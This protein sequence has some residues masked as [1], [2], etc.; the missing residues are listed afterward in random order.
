MHMKAKLT[1]LVGYIAINATPVVSWSSSLRIETGLSPAQPA[2]LVI[3]TPGARRPAACRQNVLANPASPESDATNADP[4][5]RAT[6]PSHPARALLSPPIGRSSL[7]SAGKSPSDILPPVLI[8]LMKVIA[9]FLIGLIAQFSSVDANP[10]LERRGCHITIPSNYVYDTSRGTLH[11]YCTK[12]PDTWG[13]VD[14][15]GGCARH[16]LCFSKLGGSAVGEQKCNDQLLKDLKA[17]CECDFGSLNP[18]RYACVAI[19]GSYHLIVSAATS[20]KLCKENIRY[21]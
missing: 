6:P 15:R 2:K 10:V 3:A 19:A 11:D 18:K 13:N 9:I 17:E 20:Y 21:C 7:L 8:V 1:P 4:P 16:D 14:F 12:S 5:S